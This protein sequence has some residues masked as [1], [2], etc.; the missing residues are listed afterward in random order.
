[1]SERPREERPEGL[2]T[3]PPPRRFYKE[4]GSSAGE[5]GFL[6]LLDG[7]PALT[8]GRNRLVLPR[9]DLA[10][11]AVEEWA[12]QGEFLRPLTMPLT[13]LANAAI[14]GVAGQ[15]GP[16]RAEIVKYAGSDLVCYR[17]DEPESLVERQKAHWDPVLGF[18]REALGAHFSVQ[19]GIVFIKQPPEAIAAFAQAIGAYDGLDLAALHVMTT[20]SGSALIALSVARGWMSAEAAFDAAHVDEDWNRERWGGDEEAAERRALRRLDMLAAAK[21]FQL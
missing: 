14:D 4:A 10:A 19:A 8:P 9:A 11:M 7:K 13:R 17:A 21:I 12:A 15:E 6:I 3:T 20:I 18:V 2:K 1:M 5:D 16:V